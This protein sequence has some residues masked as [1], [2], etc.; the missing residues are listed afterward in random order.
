[1]SHPCLIPSASQGSG[2]MWSP[3][4]RGWEEALLASSP[5]GAQG[6]PSPVPPTH[7]APWLL[8]SSFC[9]GELHLK[10][11]LEEGTC[12]HTQPKP[13]IAYPQTSSLLL[14]LQFLLFPAAPRWGWK[15]KRSVHRVCK[16]VSGVLFH[17]TP[18]RTSSESETASSPHGVQTDL[19]CFAWVR[20]GEP[21]SAGVRAGLLAHCTSLCIPSLF[22]MQIKLMRIRNIM[23]P[24]HRSS[25]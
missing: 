7:P 10:P 22:P 2:L 23:E 8:I 25:R 9:Q 4:N 3:Y 12:M 11:D 24:I 5:E 18:S 16:A 6:R 17:L 14:L 20:G 1:M 19:H 15:K 13:G 21:S